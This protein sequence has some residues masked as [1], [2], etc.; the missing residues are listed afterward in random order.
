[1]KG[2]DSDMPYSC[3]SKEVREYAR[4]CE[5]LIGESA[6][7]SGRLTKLE[8]DLVNY[9]TNEVVKCI[10]EQFSPLDADHVST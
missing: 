6:R 4:A 10:K 9:Y 5:H 3:F 7:G 1:M 2:T 8:L